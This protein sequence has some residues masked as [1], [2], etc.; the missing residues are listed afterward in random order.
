MTVGA[1]GGVHPAVALM[2]NA[3]DDARKAAGMLGADEVWTA[4]AGDLITLLRA[5]SRLESA[6][7]AVGHALVREADV[8]GLAAEHGQH[9]TGAWLAQLLTLHPGEASSRVKTADL[10][11]RKAT[12]T[13]AALAAGKINASQAR[14]AAAA[15]RKIEPHA[16]AAEFTQAQEFLLREGAGLH[17]GHIT[18]LGRHIEAVLDPDGEP[19]RAERA[20]SRSVSSSGLADPDRR[21]RA[22]RRHCLT[23]GGPAPTARRNSH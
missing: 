18:R 9:S 3:V 21:G 11:A 13:A 17:A 2:A 15:L 23:L 22:P 7:A 10:L 16:S 6:T 1:V 12:D 20:P 4:T 14:A 19:E 5:Q 8:R